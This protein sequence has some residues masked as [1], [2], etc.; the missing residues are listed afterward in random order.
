MAS[1]AS[2]LF[3]AG[4]TMDRSRAIKAILLAGCAAATI[5]LVYISIFTY[6]VSGIGPLRILQ[7]VATGLLGAA[8]YD[9]GYGS[10]VLGFIC[11]YVILIIAATMFWAAS[12][13]IPFLTR[14]ALIAGVLFGLAIWLVMNFIIVPLSAAPPRQITLTLGTVCNFIAHLVLIGPTLSLVMRKYAG[15]I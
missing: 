4:S 3:S 14:Q 15:R 9:G 7:S 11:H 8:S 5:D 10:G 6:V 1:S 2:D 12:R 13:K